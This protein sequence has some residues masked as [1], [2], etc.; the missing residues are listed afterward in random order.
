MTLFMR[1]PY[2][3]VYDDR[4]LSHTTVVYGNIRCPYTSAYDNRI[5][6]VRN[7][8]IYVICANIKELIQFKQAFTYETNNTEIPTLAALSDGGDDAFATRR[9]G[10]RCVGI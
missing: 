8:S 1:S 4:I 7:G 6:A 5:C 9:V 10:A 3:L 2:A